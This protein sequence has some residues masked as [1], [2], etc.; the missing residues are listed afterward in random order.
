MLLVLAIAL[1]SFGAYRMRT[2]S[3]GAVT[4]I[5]LLAGLSLLAGFCYASGSVLDIEGASCN[6]EVKHRYDAGGATLASLCP[7]PITIVAI[8]PCNGSGPTDVTCDPLPSLCKV[9]Q[10]LT[11]G[12]ECE[13]PPCCS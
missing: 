12:Q 11:N 3:A 1:I 10:T 2:R 8:D 13:L 5:A 4:G 9:N 6:N 7:N